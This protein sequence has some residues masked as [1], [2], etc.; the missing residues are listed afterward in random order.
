MPKLR[1][2]S[3]RTRRLLARSRTVIASYVGIALQA[4]AEAQPYLG[5]VQ[6]HLPPGLFRVLSIVCFAA[7]IYYR[8][9]AKDRPTDG[10][11]A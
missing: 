3:K 1:A 11:G 9:N 2:P 8:V 10:A 5:G 6:E 4:L 7:A